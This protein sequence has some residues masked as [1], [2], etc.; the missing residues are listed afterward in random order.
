MKRIYSDLIGYQMTSEVGSV[1][2]RLVDENGSHY[3]PNLIIPNMLALKNLRDY[4]NE[5]L[6]EHSSYFKENDPLEEKAK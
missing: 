1:E 2:V 4:C 3:R 5:V 6:E